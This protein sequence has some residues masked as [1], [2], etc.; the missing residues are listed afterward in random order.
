MIRIL[1]VDDDLNMLNFVLAELHQSGCEVIDADEV[2]LAFDRFYRADQAR[3]RSLK[4]SG[5]G[6][7]S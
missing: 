7:A 1:A 2:A 6:L 3:V 5:L 4:G